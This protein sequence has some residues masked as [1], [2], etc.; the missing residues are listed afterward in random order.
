MLWWLWMSVT[1]KF[2][3]WTSY[4]LQSLFELAV[5][6]LAGS[7]L[8]EMP[9]P[10]ALSL[11]DNLFLDTY[12]YLHDSYMHLQRSRVIAAAVAGRSW[13]SWCI[14]TRGAD[15]NNQFEEHSSD[16]D[17]V[18]A[19]SW[20]KLCRPFFGPFLFSSLM[21]MLSKTAKC[22]NG[23]GGYWGYEVDSEERQPDFWN[24]CWTCF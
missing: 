24:I 13:L 9:Q 10:I 2:L 14:E 15:A 12:W 1:R 4:Q 17:F 20:R 11:E 8:W 23:I 7:V 3:S 21:F 19:D 18:E 22:H 5:I 16:R 6:K